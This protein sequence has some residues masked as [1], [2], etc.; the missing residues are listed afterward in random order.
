M[1]CSSAS[2]G[3]GS[4]GI[5]VGG[6]VTGQ[7]G[8]AAITWVVSWA[9]E[10]T[11]S[12]VTWLCGLRAW[13]VMVSSSPS[14]IQFAIRDEPPWDRNGVVRPVSGSSRVTPPMITNTWIANTNDSPAASSLPNGSRQ[15]SAVRSPRAISR[16]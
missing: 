7:A 15:I 8:A 4:S 13:W 10:A 16:A 3:A 1:G 14:I 5:P 2:E 12:A 9:S 11:G 6:S